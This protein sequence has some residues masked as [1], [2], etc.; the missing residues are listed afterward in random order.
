MTTNQG[1]IDA[2]RDWICDCQWREDWVQMLKESEII[3][4]INA[5]YDGGWKQFLINGGFE[6]G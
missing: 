6:N 1:L 5:H 3:A 4:G 2:A